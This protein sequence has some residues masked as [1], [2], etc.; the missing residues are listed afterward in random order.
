MPIF[1]AAVGH[2]TN[3]VSDL[4]DAVQF[5]VVK[6]HHVSQEYVRAQN[7]DVLQPLNWPPAIVVQVGLNGLG[8]VDAVDSHAG[9]VFISY[10]FGSL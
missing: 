3:L 5:R 1:T 9:A 10:A 7:A 8:R 2:M 4:A 6:P